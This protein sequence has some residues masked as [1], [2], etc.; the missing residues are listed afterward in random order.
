MKAISFWRRLASILFALLACVFCMMPAASAAE[1]VDTSRT[2]S[3]TVYFGEDGEDFEGVSFAL[4]RVADISASGT[5]TLAGDFR[6]YP[7][8]LENLTSSGWRALA[9][10]LS[11]YVYRDGLR[12]LAREQTNR[13]GEARF[14][15]LSTG[16]YL[17][18]GEQYRDGS[19]IYTPEPMLVSLPGK[20][21]ERWDY[22]VEA[23]CKF[24]SDKIPSGSET[25]TRKVLKV[26]DDEGYEGNRPSSITVLLLRNGTVVDTVRLNRQNNW[27]H[28]WTGLD[29]GYVWQVVEEGTPEG[30]TVSVSREGITFVMTN[31]FTP[32]ETPY[33]PP[34]EPSGPSYPSSETPSEP[35]EP[36][37]PT[38]PSKP[39]ETA[40]TIPQTGVLWW[41]VPL[42]ISGGLFLLL[43]GFLLRYKQEVQDD[44]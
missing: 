22:Q 25:V 42:L 6:S 36:S 30:Y 15:R 17:L 39:P 24:D 5:F 10:T 4:Y 7:V 37:T 44:A 12:P 19:Y 32:P 8:S 21:G 18:I 2:G 14:S 34:S 3:L 23:N 20:S 27:R 41:P 11:A 38:V 1:T 9:Q 33:K 13:Y 29:A 35:T 28:T 26:W 16:L 40:E 43:L 31:T